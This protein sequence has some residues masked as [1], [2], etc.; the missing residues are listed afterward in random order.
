M[1]GDAVSDSVQMRDFTKKRKPVQFAYSGVVYRCYPG[2]A[3]ES[4]QELLQYAEGV[5]ASNAL[6]SLDS[7]FGLVMNADNAALIRAK[8]R[9][10]EDPLELDTAADI[11]M[12]VLEQYGLRPT[13]SSPDS[14][15]GSPTGADGTPSMAGA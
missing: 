3:P 7:F 4:L 1:I 14:S 12:W 5:D 9:D 10:R 11:M 6:T 2:L 13:Q 8:L 15:N